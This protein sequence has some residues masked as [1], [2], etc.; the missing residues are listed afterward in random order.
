MCMLVA[1]DRTDALSAPGSSLII[2][3]LPLKWWDM[4]CELLKA[5]VACEAMGTGTTFS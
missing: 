1:M 3:Y 5:G 2:C 4:V